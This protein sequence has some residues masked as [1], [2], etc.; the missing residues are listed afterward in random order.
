[1]KKCLLNGVEYLIP[2][3]YLN[4]VINKLDGEKE[5]YVIN[6]LNDIGPYRNSPVI[7]LLICDERYLGTFI[8]ENLEFSYK[9]SQFSL[10]SGSFCDFDSERR[11]FISLLENEN[12]LFRVNN[13]SEGIPDYKPRSSHR[14]QICGLG[15]VGGT[16]LTGLRLL[17]GPEITSIGIYDRNE[18]KKERWYR[19]ANQILKPDLSFMPPVTKLSE[20]E[21]FDTDVF[22][23]CVTAAVPEL[24]EEKNVDVRMIQFEKN[25]A[26]VESY[27]KMAH[28]RG[29]KGDFFIVSDP[30]DH[31]CMAAH[32]LKLLKSHQ[33]RGFG[34]GVMYARAVFNAL[35][36]GLDPGDLRVFG[37]HGEGLMVLNS[38]KDY[39][40]LISAK[41][42]ELTKKENIEVRK[43]GFKPYI[44]PAMSSGALSILACLKGEWHYSS[45]LLDG[46]WFG[47]RNMTDGVYS[48]YECMPLT[49]DFNE[50]LASTRRLIEDS[51]DQARKA[52]P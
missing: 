50:G 6:D 20:A 14:L 32:S 9:D 18:E 46:I 43:T 30:V 31:L 11:T 3:I 49:Q 13:I 36:L 41:L 40:P 22:I 35:S 12:T 52:E 10:L 29:Y 27:V 4:E 8:S 34:L 39:D 19:E 21:L 15:D 38:L 28:E 25:A 47:A 37:P 33:I 23:F 2:D 26:I 45:T 44:A 51:F 48:R 5:T 42:T 1:M 16:L 7:N 24:G 17:A